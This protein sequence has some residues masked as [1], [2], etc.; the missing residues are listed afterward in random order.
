MTKKAVLSL[1]ALSALLIFACS[2][3]T[4][5]S[6]EEDNPNAIF[7]AA[8]ETASVQ[9]TQVALDTLGTA[10]PPQ[11]PTL[12]PTLPQPTSILPTA[13]PPTTVPSPTEDRCDKAAFVKD[14][15]I[16]DGTR[17]TPGKAFT[18]TWRLKNIGTC[19]W[20]TNYALVFDSG[21]Q[22]GGPVEQPLTANVA[23]GETIDISV[24]L[25]APATAGTYTGNWQIRNA[26][27]VLFA[28]VY[29]QIKVGGEDFAV[30][31]V[32]D[33]S[34]YYI[35]GRGVS[36]TA[37]MTVSKAGTVKYH[38]IFR[39]NG[40]ADITTATES[41]SFSSAGTQDIGI[42]WTGC[43]HSGNFTASLYVD[44]PNH[45]EFGHADFSCP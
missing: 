17:L 42:L 36:V 25:V 24:N 22:M 26:S 11:P 16:P 15:T 30:T 45:Q 7:T 13:I 27:G 19:T 29:V 44:D 35:S 18:K 41:I 31:S 38:W 2:L 3:P 32:R 34:A 6:T 14:V 37:K 9:L 5:A 21:T 33:M 8:A 20:T 10:Q 39:E 40:H 28:K 1:L 12:A 43:P 23:P 4:G